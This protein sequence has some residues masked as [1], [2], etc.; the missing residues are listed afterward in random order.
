MKEIAKGEAARNTV[1]KW[2]TLMGWCVWQY[3]I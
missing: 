1:V 3:R 2:T